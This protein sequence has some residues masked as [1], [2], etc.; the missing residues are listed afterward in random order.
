MTT[1]YPVVKT[2]EAI[3]GEGFTTLN[4]SRTDGKKGKSGSVIVVPGLSDSV[5]FLIQGADVGKAFIVDAVD[6]LRSRMASSINGKGN[7]V[8]SDKLG[9]D[10]ILAAMKLETESQRLTKD[11]IGAWFDTA[12]LH[13]MQARF[14]VKLP[15]ISDL[16]MANITDQ[17]RAKFQSLAGR[18]G[19]IPDAIKS[20]L[21][22]AMELLHE[23]YESI[24]GTKILEKLTAV[25]DDSMLELL[26]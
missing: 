6:A 1:M 3:V 19:F 10:A 14:A 5:L 11:S 22:T 9:I 17:Y 16:K 8:T 24:I 23:D 20:Q 12:L 7:T 26:D 15:G 13:L 4:I 25:T 2:A 21:V 18:D